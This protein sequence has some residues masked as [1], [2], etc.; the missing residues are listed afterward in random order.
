MTA[1]NLVLGNL[2]YIDNQM[3]EDYIHAALSPL[4]VDYHYRL[5]RVA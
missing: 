2:D 4:G 3:A 1:R 5:G